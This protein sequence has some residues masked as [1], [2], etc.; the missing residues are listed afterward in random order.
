MGPLFSLETVEN[1][2]AVPAPSTSMESQLA[3]CQKLGQENWSGISFTEA[4]GRLKHGGAFQPL[5]VNHQFLG[6][7]DDYR[8]RA[9]ENMLG[10]IQYGII[11]QREAFEEAAS[12]LFTAYPQAREEFTK[13]FS[14]STAKF[15]T[16]SQDLVQ[17]VCGKRREVIGKRRDQ[18][19]PADPGLKRQLSAVP[20]S[21]S[22]L[23]SEEG[24]AKC[25]IPVA[26]KPRAGP[27]APK[28]RYN[29]DGRGTHHAGP[30]PPKVRRRTAPTLAPAPARPA[31]P[32]RASR[33]PPTF[34]NRPKNSSHNRSGPTRRF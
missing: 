3:I 15:R 18:F 7:R 16:I 21:T 29:H 6:Q 20:P 33:A 24:L 10:V 1:A 22:H 14:S 31:A 34:S 27:S 4:E 9:N 12:A 17:Y 32:T 13:L 25:S 2:P 28:R 8:H 19:I 23:F 26:P 30:P 11:A 5:Q